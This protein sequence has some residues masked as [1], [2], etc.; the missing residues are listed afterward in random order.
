ML[1][2]IGL[3][4]LAAA[5]IFISG[6]Y[7]KREKKR[8]FELREFIRFTSHARHKI[9]CFLSPKSDWLSDFK[10]ESRELSEFLRLSENSGFEESF[11]AVR[12]KLSLKGEAEILARLFS[13]LGRDYKEGVLMLLEGA[14]SELSCEEKR[15]SEE[16]EKNVKAVKVLAAAISLGLI[17]LLI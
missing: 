16:S 15:I 5:G 12:D 1:K 8:L 9:S 2:Y 7:E 10:T 6:E 14:I 13:S 17:I 3:L 4:M 11:E